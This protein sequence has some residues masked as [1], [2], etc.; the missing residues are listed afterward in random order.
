M[1]GTFGYLISKKGARKLLDF[2]N[3][4]GMTNGI[5][6]VQ[7]K[8]A[9]T[10]NIYYCTPHLVYSK[11]YFPGEEVDTD[12]QHDFK[13]LTI[14]YK[15][16]IEIERKFYN[17]DIIELEGDTNLSIQDKVVFYTNTNK[18]IISKLENIL[19]CPFYTIGNTIIIIPKPTTYQLE[20]RYFKRLEK[21]SK[22][23][24]DDCFLTAPLIK[25]VAF[26]DNSLCERGSTIALY[27]YAHFNETYLKNES[28]IFYQSHMPVNHSRVIEKF[29]TRFQ[30]LQEYDPV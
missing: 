9:D 10:L 19:P 1:G 25:K 4:T 12:I 15:E 17:S 29:K 30:D 24:I 6:T 16:R 23:N 18:E 20:N 14:P 27:D 13:S 2:I 22:F 26:Y 28:Y 3:K 7:Q 5:D 8:A 21:N 11:C